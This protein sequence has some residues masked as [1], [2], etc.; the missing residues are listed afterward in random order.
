MYIYTGHFRHRHCL[1]P[2][3]CPM[4]PRRNR[5]QLQISATLCMRGPLAAG[6]QRAQEQRADQ[7]KRAGESRPLRTA[8]DHWRTNKKGPALQGPHLQVRQPWGLLYTASQRP[9]GNEPWLTAMLTSSEMHPLPASFP[10]LSQFP[11]SLKG[12]SWASFP[13]E[14]T[15]FHILISGSA[16]RR[17]QL[18]SEGMRKGFYWL[19]GRIIKKVLE[20]IDLRETNRNNFTLIHVCLWYSHQNKTI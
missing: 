12:T 18:K 14:I 1:Q 11:H 2:S 7:T 8:L 10:S 20:T 4:H 5:F 15:C 6:M 17:T 13:K 9:W 16:S 19:G 3:L